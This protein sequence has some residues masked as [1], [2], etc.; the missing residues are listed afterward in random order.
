MV[1]LT[2]KGGTERHVYFNQNGKVKRH[3]QL[4]FD[5][6]KMA[7]DCSDQVVTS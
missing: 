1:I 6:F 3:L 5:D 4:I 2:S 7:S